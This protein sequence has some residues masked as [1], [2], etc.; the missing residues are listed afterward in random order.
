M[1]KQKLISQESD[2]TPFEYLV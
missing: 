1:Q 2:E